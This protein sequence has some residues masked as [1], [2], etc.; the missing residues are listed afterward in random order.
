[1]SNVSMNRPVHLAR[2]DKFYEKALVLLAGESFEEPLSERVWRVEKLI[3]NLES[4]YLEGVHA[5]RGVECDVSEINFLKVLELILDSAKAVQAMVNHENLLEQDKSFLHQFLGA[6]LD[7]INEDKNKY[8]KRA[9]NILRG[10]Q[11][12]V[13]TAQ[14]AFEKVR[15]ANLKELALECQERYEKTSVSLS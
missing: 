10:I 11:D 2:R 8:R 9:K 3:F 13:R 12:L 7:K 1:M 14:S 5:K 15:K 4:A 6:S